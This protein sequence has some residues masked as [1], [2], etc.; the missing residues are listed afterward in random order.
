M[1]SMQKVGRTATT[2]RT[3]AGVTRVRYHQ[4]DVVQFTADVITLDSG[5]W[6][7]ATTK[8]RMNQASHQFNLGFRVYQERGVWWVWMLADGSRV[9]FADGMTIPRT[10]LVWTGERWVAQP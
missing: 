7:T 5:G 10:A 1:A 9:A 8:A 6:R 4:T 2:I 3:D